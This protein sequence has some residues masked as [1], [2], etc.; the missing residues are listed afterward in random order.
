MNNTEF[1]DYL[2][3]VAKTIQTDYYNKKDA[4]AAMIALLEK[5][6]ELHENITGDKIVIRGT[7][8]LAEAL[9]GSHPLTR[10]K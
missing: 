6:D 2:K 3:L 8:T 10:L 7:K 1:S 4:T 5:T 9:S